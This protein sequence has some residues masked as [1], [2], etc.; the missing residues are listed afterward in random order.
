[1]ALSV[2]QARFV[3][4][5][6]TMKVAHGSIRSAKTTAQIVDWLRWVPTAPPAA[7][8]IIGRTKDTAGRNVVAV[9]EQMAPSVVSWRPGAS[10]A[11]IMGRQ[12]HILGANDKASETK[13]RGITLAGAL[14]DETTVL[15]EAFFT[16]LLGRLSP[17][18]ARLIATTNPDNPNHWLKTKYLDR[19]EYLGWL[20]Q[21]FTMDDNPGLTEEYRAR[22]GREY[23]GLFHERFIRGKWVAA[24]GAIYDMWDPARH[25][26]PWQD[27]PII[28]RYAALGV[29]YGTTNA[30]SAILL[31]QSGTGDWYLVDEWRYEAGENQRRLTD[32]NLSAALR[33]WLGHSHVP[34]QHEPPLPPVVVDPSAASFKQQLT[35]DG[36][37]VV[38][39]ENSV[40]DGIRQVSSL[41]GATTPL[42]VSDRCVGFI[43][44]VSGY[45]WD[46][47]ATDKGE[48]RPV[49]QNDHSMDAARYAVMEAFP[50]LHRGTTG[51]DGIG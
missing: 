40:L 18:G 48:D 4:D 37:P 44:E 46:T 31:G 5:P 25:V 49:K 41:L 34:Q 6:N 19:A 24:E 45:A 50:L 29:D 17:V 30:T 7:L 43:G 23:T 33:Q 9:M 32:A 12:H 11:T 21:H 8:A 27:L 15:P 3:R 39:A 28:V 35:A 13:V 22:M 47:K 38:D 2:A 1:M 42:R 51:I 10:T 16:T 36:I 26:V 14:V 20:V